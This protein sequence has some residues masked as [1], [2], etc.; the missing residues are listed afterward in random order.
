MLNYFKLLR[1][2]QWTKNL[3]IF[4][5]AF[6][7]GNI[8]EEAVFIKTAIGFL[9]FSFVASSIY[10][11]NDFRDIEQDKIHPTKK[12]RPLA[13]GKI[14]SQSALLVSVLLAT[15]GIILSFYLNFHF[16]L[17][18][19]G[20]LIL[21]IG[22]SFGLKNY[23]IID[24]LIISSGFLIRTVS[25]G[26]ISEVKISMWLIIM[27]F[28]LALFLA[29]SKRR[30]DILM[31]NNSGVKMRKVI[32]EYNMAFINSSITMISGVIIVAYIMY[33]TSEEVINRW[34]SEY[35]YITSLF[36]VAGI[37]KYL[38]ITFVEQASG[39]PSK[40]LL[41]NKFIIATLL[42]WVISFYFL[43]YV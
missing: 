20:Y 33:T 25:G 32:L 17:L 41:K 38:Q 15:I 24:I 4:I 36:V 22:Y 34:H 11:V 10:I 29:L 42:L 18:L 12:F 35:I 30:D 9:A 3:F 2:H 6:F 39:S 27:I 13:S 19:I 40:I 31:Y 23:S 28:L 5:P 16:G 26:I 1:P 21:N 43:I 8:F 37:L 7:A 14:S